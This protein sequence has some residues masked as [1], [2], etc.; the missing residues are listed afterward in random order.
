MD[1][2]FIELAWE[3]TLIKGEGMRLVLLERFV[4]GNVRRGMSNEYE[5][6]HW[7][8]GRTIAV[9]SPNRR[10]FPRFSQASNRFLLNRSS[11]DPPVHHRRR[12]WRANVFVSTRHD[13]KREKTNRNDH[14]AR[15]TIAMFHSTGDCSN[16]ERLPFVVYNRHQ[17]R[18]RRRHR[19]HRQRYLHHEVVSLRQWWQISF[20]PCWSEIEVKAP[21][22]TVESI[23]ASVFLYWSTLAPM[24][25]CMTRKIRVFAPHL[26]LIQHR[27][28]NRSRDDEQMT[29]YFT[30]SSKRTMR[31]PY[32]MYVR[33]VLDDTQFQRSEF[34]V[35]P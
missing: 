24:C 17:D 27:M 23:A 16:S 34:L 11:L 29:I 20:Q 12:L 8:E 33:S 31:K 25:W 2:E 14:R 18:L 32:G 15:F 19:W 10:N 26:E 22:I 28:V 4:E 3:M 7:I 9:V 35:V 30:S 5:F 6:H 1:E 13:C 21:V